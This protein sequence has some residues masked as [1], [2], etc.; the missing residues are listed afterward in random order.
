MQ[1]KNTLPIYLLAVGK[2]RIAKPRISRLDSL[3][4]QVEFASPWGSLLFRINA[5]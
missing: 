1:R 5:Q 3:T 2:K 4:G